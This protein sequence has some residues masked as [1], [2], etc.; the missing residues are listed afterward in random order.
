MRILIYGA[1]VIGSLYAA[2]LHESGQSVSVLAR[3][4]RLH[5]LRRHGLVIAE[6]PN[7]PAATVPV[8]VID[9]LDEESSYDFVLVPVGFDQLQATLSPLAD[10]PNAPNVV[11][12]GNNPAG[13][14]NL[15]A[16]LGPDRVMLGFPSA[17]G[18]L[19]GHVVRYVMIAQQ[20]TTL[21]EPDGGS[22]PR[23]HWI[24]A[25]LRQAGF[26]TE[27]S[28][29]MDRWLKTH[30]AFITMTEA[31]L[32]SVGGDASALARDP[33][34]LTL[35]VHAIREAFRALQAVGDF[36]APANLTWLGRRLPDAFATRY[37]RRALQ[38]PMGEYSLSSHAVAQRD[39]VRLMAAEV[40]RILRGSG[41]GIKSVERI[42][43]DASL[44]IDLG[45][46]ALSSQ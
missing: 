3:G 20:A 26:K 24:S 37:W 45:Q 15:T 40:L 4:K 9:T 8:K 30:A 11:F 29:H 16:A 46:P 35:M 34:A 5:D 33:R 7:G 44:S 6:A 14:A 12:F 27:L 42:L 10:L 39:E 1:G 36:E 21:G 13:S 31:A 28:G 23:L 22:T 19:D 17:G 25:A 38:T 41:R 2:R 43:T 18:R 32:L